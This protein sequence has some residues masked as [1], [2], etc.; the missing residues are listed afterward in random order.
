MD[1][2]IVIGA[3]RKKIIQ[4]GQSDFSVFAEHY[5]K[6]SSLKGRA[7]FGRSQ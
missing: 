2:K 6:M 3:L 1:R 4:K 7:C 5:S